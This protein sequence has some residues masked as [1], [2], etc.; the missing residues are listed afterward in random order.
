MVLYEE[1]V[2]NIPCRFGCDQLAVILFVGSRF[3]CKALP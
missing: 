3:I 2:G 1:L